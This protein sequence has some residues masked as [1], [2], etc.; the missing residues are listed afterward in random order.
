MYDILR[1]LLYRMNFY[2]QENSFVE[3]KKKD[4]PPKSLQKLFAMTRHRYK[5]SLCSFI[6]IKIISY[7]PSYLCRLIS[8][9]KYRMNSRGWIVS[10]ISILCIFS[11][12][13]NGLF[14]LL[15][16]NYCVLPFFRVLS[17]FFLYFFLQ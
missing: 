15:L 14:I 2:F 12:V 3:Q 17:F 13:W 16:F 8:R 9:N 11:E 4:F 1:N 7:I 5:I 10:I 6:R